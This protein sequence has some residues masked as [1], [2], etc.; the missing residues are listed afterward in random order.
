MPEKT[1]TLEIVTPDKVVTSDD[2]VVSLTV[3]GAE[4]YLG[5]LADHAPLMTELAIG[6]ITVRR[7]DGQTM[8]IAGT[9]GFMEVSNNKVTILVKTA[10]KAEEIDIARAKEAE[11]RA[12]ERLAHAEGVDFARADIALKR[13]VNRIRVAERRI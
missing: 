8:I 12:R 4:G 5:I 13:A 9:D 10:E 1:F 6:E 2:E 3:P 7:A 11:V